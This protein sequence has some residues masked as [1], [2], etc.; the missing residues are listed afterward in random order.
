M[1]V[2]VCC[3]N[4]ECNKRSRVPGDFRGGAVRCKH[5]GRRFKA[6]ATVAGALPARGETVHPEAMRLTRDRT[7][8][9]A[10]GLSGGGPGR[11]GRFEVKCRLGAGAFGSV[12]RA[13]DP[14][15]DRDVA[16]K[17]PQ[18]GLLSDPGSVERFLRETRAAAQLRHPN[19]V[20]LHEA[21]HD[22]AIYYIAAM[23]V[24]GSTLAKAAREGPFEPRRAARIV[25]GLAAALNHAH[26]AGIVHRDVKPANVLLDAR[27]RPHLADFG[28]AFRRGGGDKLMQDGTV[29]GTPAY[30]AP[31]QAAGQQGEARPAA[32]QYSLGVVLYELL[33][34]GV[35]FEGPV[36]A[37]LYKAIHEEPDPPQ[38]RNP[39]V[40][41]DLETVCL[42]AMAKRPGDRYPDCQALADDLRRWVEGDPVSVRP[43]GRGERLLRWARRNPLVAGSAGAAVAALVLGAS[44]TAAFAVEANARL[45]RAEAAAAAREEALAR[46]DEKA[47]E[48]AAQAE[49][50]LREKARAEEKAA[51]A[52][53]E[54][55]RADEKADE[56]EKERGR[57]ET[58]AGGA[59]AA[60]RLA[61]SALYASRIQLAA[62]AWNETRPGRARELLAE[63]LPRPGEPDR[64]SFEWFY[65]WRLCNA[66]RLVLKPGGK[67]QG[68]AYSPD[69][70][71][72]AAVASDHKV[73]VW[74]AAGGRELHT[75]E[76]PNV[77]GR[78]T[79]AFAPDG[80][81]VAGGAFATV[82]VWDGEGRLVREIDPL[83]GGRPP[84]RD[85][86]VTSIACAANGR[87]A[88]A[89]SDGEVLVWKGL[90]GAKVFALKLEKVWHP[91]IALSPD[92]NLLATG[93]DR[94]PVRLW[95]GE[96]KQLRVLDVGRAFVNSLAFSPDG[97]RLAAACRDGKLRFW[98]VAT[99]ALRFSTDFSTE[100]NLRSAEAV[101]YSPDDKLFAA[102]GYDRTV[103]VFDRKSGMPYRTFRGH[104]NVISALAFR[105]GGTDVA[106][107]S[108]DGTVRVWD[109]AG[110]DQVSVRLK[111]PKQTVESL[112]FSLDGRRLVAAAND[113]TARVWDA[114]GKEFLSLSGLARN[115]AS[116]ALTPDGRRVVCISDKGV[117]R[118]YDEKGAELLSFAGH[119]H[120]AVT[121]AVSPD[122]KSVAS[123]CSFPEPEVAVWDL[124][125]GQAKAVWKPGPERKYMN[126]VK[127]LAFSP[128]SRR[129]AGAFGVGEVHAWDAADGKEILALTAH[130]RQARMVCFSPDG[131]R[132]A[133]CSG[134][135]NEEGECKVWDARTG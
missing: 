73:R 123:A 69:G 11:I 95:D 5:C 132:L 116:A 68:L 22:G 84:Q 15:L 56:A 52:A 57:A 72:L 85:R 35:P 1:A 20:P 9:E 14:Q 43:L 66:E 103:R 38:K 82:R 67:R 98:D 23:F 19:I 65:L 120:P 121:L 42:K 70:K 106:T 119:K 135:W 105:P 53:R 47:D 86:N 118:V 37:V 54:K 131:A 6:A 39:E 88:I 111:G 133:T 41:E 34:G 45:R 17:V 97:Q 30:M 24:E 91:V 100:W 94:D 128:D 63:Y 89:Y 74:D 36:Q 92:A 29:L 114:A 83:P 16:L 130:A 32:D 59:Q 108:W 110:D 44:V 112:G 129:L 79:L 50:V 93:D 71:R 21:G 107:A 117:P 96:G 48:A 51:E 49:L 31:E 99:G 80:A 13:Y 126:G 7:G 28:L 2:L 125:T 62:T 134:W 76:I 18:V 4:P 78:P 3:P 58:K 25:R 122:G 60:E 102:A 77:A 113:G 61:R 27:D 55:R 12:Y 75:H 124:Q 40:P 64:R 101:A 81:L 104:N 90:K 46:A 8:P 109:L 115:D 127:Q 87:F 26:D 33:T 10:P